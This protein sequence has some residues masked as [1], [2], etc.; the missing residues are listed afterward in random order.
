MKIDLKA[1]FQHTLRSLNEQLENSSRPT[2]TEYIRKRQANRANQNKLEQ[3]YTISY[4][5]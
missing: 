2:P 5:Y 3:F 1:S 4:F